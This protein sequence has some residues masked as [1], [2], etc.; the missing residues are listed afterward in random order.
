MSLQVPSLIVRVIHYLILPH[1]AIPIHKKLFS[2]Q[3][4]LQ[5]K[6]S[7]NFHPHKKPINNLFSYL[8]EQKLID[9]EKNN[10]ILSNAKFNVNNIYY[11]INNRQN[12]NKKREK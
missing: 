12:A 3:F 9:G 8:F 2:V 11:L 7:I 1:F 6:K 4:F 5:K 10:L